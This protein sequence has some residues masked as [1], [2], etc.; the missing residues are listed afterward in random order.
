MQEDLNKMVEEDIAYCEREWKQYSHL[1]E[2]MEELFDRMLFKYAPIV[3]GIDKDMK[4]ISSYESGNRL[5]EVYRNNI[6]ILVG[7]LQDFLICDCDNKKL[8]QF[9]IKRDN[10]N[11]GTAVSWSFHECRKAI[12]EMDTLTTKEREHIID[13]LD[14]ME[15]ICLRPISK[16]D[17]WDRLRP[18]VVWL[19]GKDLKVALEILPVFLKL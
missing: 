9:Y 2:K 12:L 4:V 14:E 18:Y 15:S 7:R 3:K 13:K 19:S 16:K 11:Q 1:L 17:K 6:K 8:E 10:P 5:A